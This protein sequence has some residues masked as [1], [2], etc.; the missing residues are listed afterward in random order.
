MKIGSV[1]I[2][3]YEFDEM[4]AFWQEVLHYLP[5]EPPKGGWVVFFYLTR[6]RPNKSMCDTVISFEYT[7]VA[8]AKSAALPARLWREI[9]VR[10]RVDPGIVS[11]IGGLDST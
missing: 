4:L 5:R 2:R 7:V 11:F 6:N 8:A 9:R 1:V 10:T 3:C